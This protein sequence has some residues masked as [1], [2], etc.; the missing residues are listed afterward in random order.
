MENDPVLLEVEGAVA[1]LTLNRPARL[2]ALDDEMRRTLSERF[3]SLRRVAGVRVVVLTG[4]GR[5]FSSGGDVREMADLKTEHH[6]APF[7]SFL[8]A[9]NELIKQ[10][11][12]LPKPVLASVNGPAAGAGMNL[13]LAC[14]LRIAS[15][16]ATFAESFF[17]VGLHPDW[18]GTYFLPRL[19]GHGRAMEMFLLGDPVTAR[20]AHRLGMVNLVVPPEHLVKETRELASRLAESPPLPVALLK[21]ELYSRQNTELH[22]ALESEVASQ[23]KCFDSEDSLEGL[24]AFLEKRKPKW[25]GE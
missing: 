16:E 21:A 9:G 20:E 22:L 10:I 11:R 2:N 17:K 6:S 23:M 19:I 18:G 8:E 12:R 25:K 24:R 7:R 1:T 13:A 3:E 15:E 4:A 14:D 5:G